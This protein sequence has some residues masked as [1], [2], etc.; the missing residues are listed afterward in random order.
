MKKPRNNANTGTDHDTSGG[1]GFDDENAWDGGIVDPTPDH[2]L[3]IYKSD[4][5][6]RFLPVHQV[7]GF[8]PIKVALDT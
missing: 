8:H 3:K 7:G 5:H 6:F 4:Q 2:S 1:N